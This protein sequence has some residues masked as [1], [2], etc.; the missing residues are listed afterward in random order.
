MNKQNNDGLVKKTID[1]WKLCGMSS[2]VG[3]D[4]CDYIRFVLWVKRFMTKN[5]K[6]LLFLY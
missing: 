1:E 6:R 2:F 3:T 4:L 5:L